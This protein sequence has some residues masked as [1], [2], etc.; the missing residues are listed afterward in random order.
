MITKDRILAIIVLILGFLVLSTRGMIAQNV[1]MKGNTFIEL[2]D[3]ITYTETKYRYRESGNSHGEHTV[4]LSKNGKAFIWKVSEKTGK[5][6][7]KYLP[8]VTEAI[9]KNEKS[10]KQ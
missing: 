10:I 5:K 4:Y 6:Y 9:H 7:R 1:V 3:S 8:K 2:K